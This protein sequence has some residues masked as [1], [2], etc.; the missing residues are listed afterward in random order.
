MRAM[1]EGYPKRK[2]L[3]SNTALLEKGAVFLCKMKLF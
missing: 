2:N 3:I 1:P